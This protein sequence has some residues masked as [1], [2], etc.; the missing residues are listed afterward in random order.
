MDAALRRYA[1]E[2]N[3][4]LSLRFYADGKSFLEEYT[5]E[6]DL[7]FMD[8]EMP[9]ISGMETAEQ[10]RERDE[11]V[12]LIFVTKLVGYAVQGYSV[13]AMDFMVKPVVYEHLAIKLDRILRTV[14][15][16]RNRRVAIQNGE[17]TKWLDVD[18]IFYVEVMNHTLFYHTRTEQMSAYGTIKDCEQK[19]T[20]QGF[21]RCSNSYLVNLRH[22][23]QVRGNDV[24]VGQAWLP[25]GRTKRKEF[26]QRLAEY[27][28]DSAL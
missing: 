19:L 3:L 10:L 12:A 4:R 8:I 26:M 2:R 15:R 1:E 5:G 23:T 9:G 17:L 14:D 27:A 21:A 20:P 13:R 22:V 25:I 16:Q 6:F 11:D 18:D 24:R 28:G 7:V